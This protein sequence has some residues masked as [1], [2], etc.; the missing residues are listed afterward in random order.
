MGA[1]RAVE[2]VLTWS[3]PVR[4]LRSIF[5]IPLSRSAFLV[6]L[7]NRGVLTLLCSLPPSLVTQVITR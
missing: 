3:L 5:S 7:A 1:Q 4:I 6:I 2:E